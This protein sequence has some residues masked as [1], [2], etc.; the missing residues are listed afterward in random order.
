MK[1]SALVLVASITANIACLVA[2]VFKPA[3]TPPSVRRFLS[4]TTS[5]GNSDAAAGAKK[6]KPISITSVVAGD[7]TGRVP[8]WDAVAS[9]DLSRLIANLRAAGFSPLMIRS[10]VGAQIDT[11]FRDRMNALAGGATEAPFWKPDATGSTMSSQFNAE[12]SQIYRERAALLRQLLGHEALNISGAG[13]TADQRRQF[14]DM[15]AAKIDLVQRIV[16]DYAEMNA[17]VQ[18]ATQGITLPSDREKTA[19]L[20]R[21]KRADLAAILT[22]EELEGYEM[23]T[24]RVTSRLRQA[25]T[26]LD[27]SDDEFRAIFRAQ[28]PHLDALYPTGTSGPDLLQ[29]RNEI[30]K[31]VA[32]NIRSALG[33][34]RYAEYLRAN[35]SDYQSLIRIGRQENISTDRLEHVYSLRDTVVKESARISEDRQLG[36]DEKKAALLALGQTIRSQI[37]SALGTA[38][39]T[40][41]QNTTWATAPERGWIARMGADGQINSFGSLPTPP[42]ARPNAN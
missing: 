19:L 38:A 12:Y 16:D 27:A 26:I 15:P 28:Q 37:T 5:A 25:L 7:D 39:E 2:L 20:E 33:E 34:A 22:P 17:R 29:R 8:R 18:T 24:S 40:F 41:M 6:N 13:I 36:T 9:Q 10:I 30:Q 23:R 35:S 3:L 14:G 11:R 1:S 4:T 31:E 21:E 42:T 32:E